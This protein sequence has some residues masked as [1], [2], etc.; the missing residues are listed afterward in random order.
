MTAHQPT[1]K[2]ARSKVLSLSD[3]YS[4]VEKLRTEAQ[5]K[6]FSLDEVRRPLFVPQRYFCGKIRAVT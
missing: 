6:P 4:Q 5:P 3:I 1:T 2:P